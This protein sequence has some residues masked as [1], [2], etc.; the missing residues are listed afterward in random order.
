MK[1]A[2]YLHRNTA[3]AD[4]ELMSPAAEVYAKSN[5]YTVTAVYADGWLDHPNGWDELTAD[6]L[7]GKVEVIV[8]L[9]LSAWHGD[10]TGFVG[11]VRPLIETDVGFAVAQAPFLGLI[12][13][14]NALMAARV[15][16]RAEQ[17][18]K[19][20]KS[21]NIRQGMKNK[22]AGVAPFGTS[23][24]DGGLVINAQEWPVVVRVM[25][26]CEDGLS[27]RDVAK[28]SNLKYQKVRTIVSYW[29]ERDWQ[30]PTL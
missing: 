5:G 1:A 10:E 4:M 2:I 3:K 27:V 30:T 12:K 11:A 24:V 18:Y 26:L 23:W 21:L 28:M 17:Y 29:G 16:L 6:A 13:T 25:Q 19:D 22:R 9:N 8:A 15:V 14:N 7:A 20:V